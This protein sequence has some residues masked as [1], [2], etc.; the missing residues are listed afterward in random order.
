MGAKGGGDGRVPC[1]GQSQWIGRGDDIPAPASKNPQYPVIAFE[2]KGLNDDPATTYY[3]LP[4]FVMCCIQTAAIT[5]V[6]SSAILPI[7]KNHFTSVK[8]PAKLATITVGLG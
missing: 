4:P 1:D 6:S 3:N 5:P 8:T 7:T 2:G